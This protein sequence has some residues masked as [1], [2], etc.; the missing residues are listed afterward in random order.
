MTAAAADIDNS[1][2]R[3]GIRV[4]LKN[5][6]PNLFVKTI[7]IDHFDTLFNDGRNVSFGVLKMAMEVGS[8]DWMMDLLVCTTKVIIERQLH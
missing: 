5:W 3:K 1:I 6:T 4:S 7:L 8:K 2:N